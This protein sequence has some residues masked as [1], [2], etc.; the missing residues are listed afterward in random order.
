MSDD[1]RAPL[2]RNKPVPPLPR[3][4]V[5]GGIACGIKTHAGRPDLAVIVAEQECVA[6]GVFTQNQVVAAPVQVSRSRLPSQRIRG[7]ILNSGNANACT[8]AEGVQNANRMA[9]L[10]AKRIGCEQDQ[11][12]VCST[13]IIGSQLPIAKI[14]AAAD[15]LFAQVHAGA[16]AVESAARGI[17]TTDTVPKW[18]G[19]AAEVDGRAVQVTGIAKGAAMM[20][21]HLATMLAVV[22][23]DAPLDLATAERILRRAVDES[24]NSMSVDGDMS[25][26]DTVLF[27]ANGAAGGA[28][29]GDAAAK[30]L[31]GLV[32]EVCIDLAQAIA[33]DGEGARHFI[34]IDVEGT[35]TRE[36]AHAVAK[37]IANSVL[38]KTAI[39]GADPNWGR[40]V[41]AA[42]YA[43]VP[44]E[45]KQLS[46]WLNDVLLYREGT[47]Q[48]F[49][50]EALSHQLRDQRDVHI[51][52]AFALADAR[53]RFWT[54][55]LTDEY[56]RL[57]AEYHT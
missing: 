28:P 42:G 7:V 14:A 25:T 27:L 54:C 17:M 55:D 34:T 50:A 36:E 23:T 15:E 10:A 57:N 21:P 1:R 30:T 48:P 6:V 41:A 22:V 16:D 29:L 26:N 49:D 3:G 46:L 4:F 13:G 53:A 39:F 37:T 32:T 52:L 24:F 12:L 47:P 2:R 40:I 31:G 5:S 9:D 43:G 38:V 19:R 18:S 44:F 11:V 20:G 8:G 35:R 45:E 33:G 56:V 51:R